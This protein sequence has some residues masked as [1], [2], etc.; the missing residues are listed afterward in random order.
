MN[1]TLEV[2]FLLLENK[3][4]QN[5]EIADK[6]DIN[7]RSIQRAVDKIQENF[8]QSIALNRYFEFFKDGRAHTVNQ[9]Y[10]LKEDQILLLSKLLVSSRSLNETELPQLT[11]RMLNM[12][13]VDKRSIVSSAIASERLTET[14]I[15]DK[16]DRQ[17]KLWQLE[18]YIFDKDKIKFEYTNHENSEAAETTTVE[19]LPVHTFFD[20]YY[21]FMIGLEKVSHEYKTYRVDWIQNIE[22]VNIKLHVEYRKRH[23]HGKDAQLNAYG[24]MGEE[25]RIRFEYYGYIGYVQDKF[26]SCKVIKK[27]DKKNKFPFSVNL[28]EIKVNYS[29]GVKLWL[30][31][32]TPILRVVEPAEIAE[33][34]K[35]T[36]YDSYRLYKDEE[37]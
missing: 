27:L 21:F 14:Y 20:N 33:D 24:Y 11:N 4:L 9:K 17:E 34:I 19:V 31:G 35:N 5:R 29:P 15:S 37:K 1:V 6:L 2:F 12:I 23:N 25:M 18:Q 8:E 32:Q 30:L 28:L 3:P 16:S 13:N 7:I 10:L 22:K 26:P 36:L